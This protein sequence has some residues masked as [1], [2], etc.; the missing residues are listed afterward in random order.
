MKASKYHYDMSIKRYRLTDRELACK[1]TNEYLDLI[2]EKL[3]L[4]S[5]YHLGQYLGVSSSSMSSYRAKKIQFDD[6]VCGRV[7]K[8]LDLPALLVIAHIQYKSDPRSDAKLFWLK[9]IKSIGE[10]FHEH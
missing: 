10:S 9:E 8:I 6:Y 5:D 2:K 4:H 3:G 1:T 7:A